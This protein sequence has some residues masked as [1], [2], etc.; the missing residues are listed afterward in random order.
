M[1]NYLNTMAPKRKPKPEAKKAKPEPK[2]SAKKAAPVKKPAQKKRKVEMKAADPK[3]FAEVLQDICKV[4]M[5]C[6]RT[7]FSDKAEMAET[8][9]IVKT[10]DFTAAKPVLD[11]LPVAAR[12]PLMQLAMIYTEQFEE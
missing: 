11:L 5:L 6:S 7:R 10:E 12:A 4:L 8:Y 1:G 9:Q 2:R 3:E